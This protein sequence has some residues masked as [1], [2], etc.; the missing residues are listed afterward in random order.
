MTRR[1]PLCRLTLALYLALPSALAL[2]G[3]LA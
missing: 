2:A 3:A 1:P